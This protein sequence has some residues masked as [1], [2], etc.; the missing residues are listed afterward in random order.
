VIP[1][2]NYLIVQA[3]GESRNDIISELTRACTQCGCN[4]LDAKINILGQEL[5]ITLF[6]SGNW[7]AIAKME[8]T[9]PSLEQKLGLTILARRTRE[10]APIGQWMTY[11]VQ[12]TAIDQ[13]GILEGIVNFLTPLNV[14]IEE[15]SANTYV[16][17]TQTRMLNLELKINV[18]DK[19]QFASL[20]EQFM[21]Y[22][23]E[24]NLDAFLEPFRG[25]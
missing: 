2:H 12:I 18:S 7:G 15:I 14:V 23:D 24:H 11:S 9:F 20:R 25:Y 13:L 16:N 1:I 5:A 4:I 19:T 22:C 6:L 8:A 10:P 21:S 17:Q 3:S